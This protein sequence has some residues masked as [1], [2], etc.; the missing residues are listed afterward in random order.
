M[1]CANITDDAIANV[2]SPQS[3]I[4]SYKGIFNIIQDG[5]YDV[6]M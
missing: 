3:C 1:K 5:K 6:T 2:I 4:K